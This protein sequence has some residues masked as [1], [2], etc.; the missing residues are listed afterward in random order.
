MTFHLSCFA[1]I[2]F[3][4]WCRLQRRRYICITLP[5]PYTFLVELSFMDYIVFVLILI[6]VHTSLFIYVCFGKINL[7]LSLALPIPAFRVLLTLPSFNW[8]TAI[9]L[10]IIYNESTNS[11]ASVVTG[12]PQFNRFLESFKNWSIILDLPSSD[13]QNPV[14]EPEQE[15]NISHFGPGQIGSGSIVATRRNLFLR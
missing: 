5:L 1:L 10:H 3:S 4:R 2:Y 15:Q 8:P 11:M 9:Q 12:F 7:N 6:L 13:E 14:Q